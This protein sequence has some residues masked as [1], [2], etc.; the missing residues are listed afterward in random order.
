MASSGSALTESKAYLSA[1]VCLN[2][3]TSSFLECIQKV[4]WSATE[5]NQSFAW[6]VSAMR[7]SSS[8]LCT[9][10][11]P[12]A[13]NSTRI[14]LDGLTRNLTKP[15]SK[16][17]KETL[18]LNLVSDTHGICLSIS[19]SQPTCMLS[20]I[21]LPPSIFGGESLMK[22]YGNAQI[23]T[24]LNV[25]IYHEEE[26]WETFGK[27]TDS[28]GIVYESIEWLRLAEHMREHMYSYSSQYRKDVEERNTSRFPDIDKLYNLYISDPWRKEAI[29]PCCTWFEY[30]G[31]TTAKTL[32]FDF[33]GKPFL[34]VTGI[35]LARCVPEVKPEVHNILNSM[36]QCLFDW[37]KRFSGYEAP[38]RDAVFGMVYALSGRVPPCFPLPTTEPTITPFTR[39]P[40]RSK[41]TRVPS[42]KFVT[43]VGP[44]NN[45][46]KDDT[47]NES[48][49]LL[50]ALRRNRHNL[51]LTRKLFVTIVRLYDI[52]QSLSV[53]HKES[54][55]SAPKDQYC[56]LSEFQYLAHLRSRYEKTLH[57]YVGDLRAIPSTSGYVTRFPFRAAVRNGL[58]STD[59]MLRSRK[60][61]FRY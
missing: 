18:R 4:A 33:V 25:S 42:I 8:S 14:A 55:R 26:G 1:E 39:H 37:K 60:Q 50:R 7:L 20:S 61:I 9:R 52:C 2:P 11:Y 17:L 32:G 30:F 21:I 45:R 12:R 19:C 53:L 36:S 24:T 47:A 48:F 51:L 49:P 3:K 58:L 15:L 57:P 43:P 13:K 29:E 31:L 5:V 16:V 27:L 23:N 44:Y 41:R 10:V 59:A 46:Y 35:D 34:Q 22:W 6:F 38:S 28:L 40:K 56:F 54:A